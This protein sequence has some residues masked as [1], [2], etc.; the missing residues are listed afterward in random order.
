MSVLARRCRP[1]ALKRLTHEQT[2]ALLSS[3]FG[4]VAHVD[5]LARELHAIALGNP[6]DTMELAQ[7]LV[8]RGLVSYS[9]GGWRLP[10]S[11]V[12]S[13]LPASTEEAFRVQLRSLSEPA[14]MLA[15]AQALAYCDVFDQEAYRQ[16]RPGADTHE[17]DRALTELLRLGTI[18]PAGDLYVLANRMWSAALL[19]QLDEAT[20]RRRHRALAELYASSSQSARIYHLFAAGEDAL[21]LD[22]LQ[23]RHKTYDKAFDESVLRDP[24]L[25]KLMAS[26]AR[27]MDAAPRL[28]RSPR[29]Q[30]DLRRWSIA[31]SSSADGTL[32]KSAVPR[33]FAQ[34]RH[35]SGLDVW[36]E[37]TL[38][39][40]GQRLTAALMRAQERY[41]ATPEGER[42]YSVEE[43]LHRLAEYVVYCIAIGA[44]SLD[45]PLL[46]SLPAALEPFA[47]LSPLLDA[48]HNN[49]LATKEVLCHSRIDGALARWRKVLAQL[50]ALPETATTHLVA[51]QNAVAFGVGML[52]AQLGIERAVQQAERLDHDLRQKLSAIQLRKQVALQQGDWT[53]A[54]RYRRQA[55]LESLQLRSLQMFRSLI[56]IELSV[57]AAAKDLVGIEHSMKQLE[58]LA[59]QSALWEAQWIDASAQFELSRG[60]YN[61]ACTRFREGLAAC[62]RGTVSDDLLPQAWI[63]LQAGLAEALLAAGQPEEARS[64]AAH[65][66]SICEARAVGSLS[67][68]VAR[69][70]ALAEAACGDFAS[71]SARLDRVLDQQ[72][73]TG[74]SG[75]WLGLTFE[76]QAR[77]AILSGAEDDFERFASLA[78]REYRRG[79]NS[80]LS[81]R[82]ERL[83]DQARRRGFQQL[84]GLP[85]MSGR[86]EL[87][88]FATSSADSR[89]LVTRALSGAT[90]AQDRSQ[91]ALRLLCDTC[92]ASAGHLFLV[93]AT[94]PR[95]AASLGS[96]KPTR[97]LL[98]VVDKY[99]SEQRDGQDAAT[100]MLD[101][102][103]DISELMSH[104]VARAGALDYE[105]MLLTS[106]TSRG[107]LKIAGVAAIATSQSR[108]R[109]AKPHKLLAALGAQLLAYGDVT[110][111]ACD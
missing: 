68:S 18:S 46:A 19:T 28:G 85:A 73:A 4:D 101:E 12:A 30:N 70:L 65:A 88:S 20:C 91:R 34:L 58:P 7:Y 80:P 27:A 63:T 48:I 93:D 110:G 50:D 95:I 57:Y 84:S 33:W 86:P 92:D 108:V 53:A 67:H 74:A 51:I 10:S 79:A 21:G 90:D 13:D 76:A 105:L 100:A 98:D 66:L 1:I 24:E 31:L 14:R 55:E 49:A 103:Q 25:W 44:R 37:S 61:A 15:E 39:D 22:E 81:A 23:K 96:N 2:R 106:E 54:E 75:I 104:A 83:L 64:C 3:L 56:A 107:E 45:L 62:A 35:D 97:E 78:G 69:A 26:Y 109:T 9:A 77:V 47:P 89:S 16:L 60:D 11:L 99:L 32:Y 72:K 36:Q 52:E 111:L 43:S 71:A 59:A 94:A 40:P 38:T 102:D 29:E 87:L 8:D 82:Y 41:L 42:V 6:G 5:Y 17:T